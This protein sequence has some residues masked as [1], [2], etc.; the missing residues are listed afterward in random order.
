MR[1]LKKQKK[2][3]NMLRFQLDIITPTS[4]TSFSDVSYLRI[5]ALDGLTGIQS[6]HANA[7][8]ALDIGE[9]K[10]TINGKDEYFSTSGGFSDIK[11]EGVQLLLETFESIKKIDKERAKNSLTR[12]QKNFN[13]KSMDLQRAQQS[14]KRAKN[15]LKLINK[16]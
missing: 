14:I 9:I 12:A 11:K 10:I 16:L 7:I 3:T 6:K 5:P 2:W 15:R 8:I 4:I 1:L 13:N